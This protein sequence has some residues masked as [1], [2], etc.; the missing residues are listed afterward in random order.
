MPQKRP[1][2][3]YINWLK[4]FQLREFC[5]FSVIKIHCLLQFDRNLDKTGWNFD[6]DKFKEYVQ[7]I[8]FNPEFKTFTSPKREFNLSDQTMTSYF[9]PDSP[10]Y[11]ALTNIYNHK[12][13]DIKSYLSGKTLLKE[14][15]I[16]S[17]LKKNLIF[18]FIKLKNLDFR[19]KLLII[20]PKITIRAKEALIAIFRYF[21]YGFI[22]EIEGEY[23]ITEFDNKI[24]FEHGLMVKLY[25]P[26]SKFRHS[27]LFLE[28]FDYIFQWLEVKHYIYL[29]DYV[30]GKR[31]LKS[32]FKDLNF[33]KYN[34]L[35]NLKWNHKDKIWMNPKIFTDK[36]EPI[37]PDLYF[38]EKSLNSKQ[39]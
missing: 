17:L 27:D 5:L 13:I 26:N 20:I 18:P 11:K 39:V 38:S 1:N 19:E 29:Y 6:Y 14:H 12:S 23:Y 30:N 4:P 21:N 15:Q 8:L 32:I 3:K 25:F 33:K 34:P 31:I 2:K 24:T 37:Y 28:L 16:T 22:Y 35:K 7:N 9:S 36:F 10:E